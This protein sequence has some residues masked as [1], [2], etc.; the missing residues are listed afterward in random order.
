[1][2]ASSVSIKSP[3]LD[4]NKNN[5]SNIFSPNSINYNVQPKFVSSNA[6]L[7]KEKSMRKPTSPG[8]SFYQI[9]KK[10]SVNH[11]KF[12]LNII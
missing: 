1:M 9:I 12:Q 4:K 10:P 2:N 11:F 3:T 8:T 7:P 6:P 5:A